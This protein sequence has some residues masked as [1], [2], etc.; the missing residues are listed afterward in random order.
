MQWVI[1][2]IESPGL[3]SIYTIINGIY[4]VKIFK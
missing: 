1:N 2:L 3:T 4:L